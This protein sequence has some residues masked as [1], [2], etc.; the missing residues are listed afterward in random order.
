M[1]SLPQGSRPHWPSGSPQLLRRKQARLAG[2]GAWAL[3]GPQVRRAQQREGRQTGAEARRAAEPGTRA[4]SDLP[5][6]D[7]HGNPPDQRSC[8]RCAWRCRSAP[9]DGGRG[10]GLQLPAPGLEKRGCWPGGRGPRTWPPG[11]GWASQVPW[12]EE[13]KTLVR[14]LGRDS[15]PGGQ[16]R[17]RRPS[18]GGLR[19]SQPH[20]PH[21]RHS[22]AGDKAATSPRAPSS[23]L[24]L[25]SFWNRGLSPGV[26][27][28]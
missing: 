17:P 2:R 4:L 9:R 10:P 16:P 5:A 20:S 27:N 28:H 8:P 14:Q 24:F 3:P 1:A 12:A 22:A 26:L 7:L 6:R 19:Q 18:P 21:A 13:R 25:F 15:L 23:F 11:G